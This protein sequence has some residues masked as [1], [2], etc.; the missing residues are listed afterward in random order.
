MLLSFEW[1]RPTKNKLLDW[2]YEEVTASARYLFR[3][4]S[5]QGG[6]VLCGESSTVAELNEALTAI[7]LLGAKVL[8]CSDAISISADAVEEMLAVGRTFDR[9]AIVGAREDGGDNPADLTCV[10]GTLPPWTLTWR[11]DDACALVDG[12]MLMS[13]GFLDPRFDSLLGALQDLSYRANDLGFSTVIANRAVFKYRN[14]A[15]R[16]CPTS[17]NGLLEQGHPE[18]YCDALAGRSRIFDAL[19]ERASRT[20]GKNPR[21]LFEFSTMSPFHCGTSEYQIALLEYF[22]ELYADKYDIYLRCNEEAIAYH[23]LKG[24]ALNVFSLDEENIPICDI[25]FVAAQPVDL[26]Q[27]LFLNEHCL[28]IVYTMLDCI[29]L[30]SGY[31]VAESPSREDLVRCGLSYADGIV[32]ISDFSCADYKNFY[33]QDSCIMQ[34]P[35]RNVY[36]ATDFGKHIDKGGEAVASPPFDEYALVVGN[37]FRH[38]ALDPTLA[39][40][41]E[42]SRNYVFVGKG[43]GRFLAKNV[44]GYPT[45]T[46]SEAFLDNLY[47]KCQCLVFPSQYEGFGLPVTIAL[48]HGKKV[49]LHDNDLNREIC[50]HFDA[51]EDHFVFFR[52]FEEIPGLVDKCIRTPIASPAAFEHSWKDAIIEVESF[53]SCLV[54]TPV[55]WRQ[56]DRRLWMYRL[57][58]TQ[59]GLAERRTRD[60]IGFKRLIRERFARKKDSDD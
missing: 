5:D 16:S 40:V 58:D 22:S 7:G 50:S 45:S 33:A 47:E 11:L 51:F 25:G 36:I 35:S 20:Y 37:G 14:D 13:V 49:V 53:V 38:K 59:I 28:R 19:L 48:K 43:E 10:S 34:V 4:L 41:A 56:I 29:L 54:S 26:Q 44:F 23:G 52:T 60:S 30:R 17:D 46:L 2:G 55:D 31:L 6:S 9:H 15:D 3:V 21:I 8:I 1:L 27:Q 18:F 39:A 42:S 57:L 24:I 12:G 32:A